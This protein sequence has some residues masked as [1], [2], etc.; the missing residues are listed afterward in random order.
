MSV[1]KPMCL[2]SFD[3]GIKNLSYCMISSNNH[4][5]IIKDWKILDISKEESTPILESKKCNCINKIKKNQD[6]NICGKKAKYEK[7]GILYCE[8]HAKTSDRFIIPCKEIE[9]KSLNKLKKIELFNIG[10]KYNILKHENII[11][12][13]KDI[14]ER[15]DEFLLVKCFIPL[16]FSKPINASDINLITLGRN[17]KKL[18]DEVPELDKVTHIILENQIS[19]IAIRMT[20]IQ[21]M[22]MQYFIMKL[23]ESVHIQFVS[24]LNKLK[25]FPR[26]DIKDNKDKYKQHKEDS[27]YHTKKILEKNNELSSWLILFNDSSSIK[28]LDDLSDSCLQG[29]WYLNHIKYLIINETYILSSPIL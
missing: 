8:T 19:T 4:D 27:I 25:I 9:K 18:L 24:S 1:P 10:I 14:M 7:L 26:R 2:L 17:M 22:L 15:I 28:K 12:T 6:N 5:V 11:Q 13:K 29:I 20:C 16:K 21:S 23:D 3:I